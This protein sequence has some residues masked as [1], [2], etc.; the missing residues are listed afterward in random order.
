[1]VEQND[2]NCIEA[3]FYSSYGKAKA[4]HDYIKEHCSHGDTDNIP[5]FL[6]NGEGG[7]SKEYAVAYKIIMDGLGMDC[8]V[9]YDKGYF[10]NIVKVDGNE[11]KIR[12][13][14]DLF[15]RLQELV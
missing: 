5:A 15:D 9:I 2:P 1:M 10:H 11:E 6:K 14:A 13:H 7:S 3:I 8:E 12:K 4:A